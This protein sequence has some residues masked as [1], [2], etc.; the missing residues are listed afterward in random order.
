MPSKATCERIHV[1]RRAMQRFGKSLSKDT[2]ARFTQ[3]IRCGS[4]SAV[5]LWRTSCN[6]SNWAVWHCGE[7][8]PVVYSK[9]TQQIITVLP[10]HVL[11]RHWAKLERPESGVEREQRP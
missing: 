9:H 8:W 3:A 10:K 2:L 5:F 7:W 11:A 4:R 6:R 1:R